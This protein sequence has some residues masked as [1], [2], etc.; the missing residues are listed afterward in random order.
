[1]TQ[2]EDGLTLIDRLE[3][4]LLAVRAA[5]GVLFAIVVG[6]ALFLVGSVVR[7]T[8]YGRR[9]EIDILRLVGATDGFIAAPFVI[10]GTAQGLAGGVVAALLVR[11]GD[12]AAL[13]R[14]AGAFGF[15]Q[16]ILPPHLGW[17]LLAL[18]AASGAALGFAASSVAVVRF[19]RNAP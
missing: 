4:V 12:V 10:E 13:P 2:V 17:P 6:V 11:A 19:L 3:T 9:D 15:A 1:V 18:L 16:E 14:M 8:V 7:L 5:G